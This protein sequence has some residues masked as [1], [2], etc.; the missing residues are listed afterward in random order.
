MILLHC[1]PKISILKFLY[2]W[3]LHLLQSTFVG[4]GIIL[5]N[6]LNSILTV[7]YLLGKN[8]FRIP[9]FFY[10]DFDAAAQYFSLALFPYP[11]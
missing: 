10:D 7:K 1:R 3:K 8:V 4:A 2:L 11:I 5:S 6:Y 9:S